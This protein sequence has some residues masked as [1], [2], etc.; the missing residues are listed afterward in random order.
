VMNVKPH[1]ILT[2]ELVAQQI[3]TIMDKNVKNVPKVVSHAQDLNNSNALVVKP[4]TNS[5]QLE[6]PVENV[7]NPMPTISQDVKK[8]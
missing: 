2:M 8:V 3:L 4:D 7:L 6:L 5:P 1:S